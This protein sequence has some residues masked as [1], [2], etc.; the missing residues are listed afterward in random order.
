MSTSSRPHEGN[1]LLDITIPAAELDPYP[2]F[3]LAFYAV[4]AN[5][6][7]IPVTF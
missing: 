6:V 7:S 1:L 4:E 3:S 5:L 2:S